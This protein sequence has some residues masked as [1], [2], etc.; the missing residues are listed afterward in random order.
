MDPGRRIHDGLGSQI[1]LVLKRLLSFVLDKETQT[2]GIQS[3]LEGAGWEALPT[4]LSPVFGVR[5]LEVPETE[6]TL[7]VMARKH[8][9]W[10]IA[11]GRIFRRFV[12]L[13][14][15]LMQKDTVH[16]GEVMGL[17]FHEKEMRAT[18]VDTGNDI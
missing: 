14:V 7:V 2:H 12:S 18:L 5:W 11:E 17:D 13:V 8:R 10:E 9:H 16:F 15:T 4:F 1:A 3:A 6:D